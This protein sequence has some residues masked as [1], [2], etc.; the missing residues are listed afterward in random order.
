MNAKP[1]MML[2]QLGSHWADA[3]NTSLK[4]RRFYSVV[5]TLTQSL[6]IIIKKIK[7]FLSQITIP[8]LIFNQTVK[9]L[10]NTGE[11]WD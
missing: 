5:L 7:F 9:T 8:N 4:Q 10:V 11:D 1:F 2:W 6:F 3:L